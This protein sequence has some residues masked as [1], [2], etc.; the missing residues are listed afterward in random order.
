MGRREIARRPWRS[1]TGPGGRH[2]ARRAPRPRRRETPATSISPINTPIGPRSEPSSAPAKRQPQSPDGSV[3]FPLELEPVPLPPVSIEPPVPIDP[4]E[5]PM[6]PSGEAVHS[7]AWQVPFE[8]GSP[9][10][11]AGAEQAPVVLSHVPSTWHSSMAVQLLGLPP[12]QTPLMH[13]S[14]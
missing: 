10:L 13:V 9:S 6:P 7:P 12:T 2:A 5:P 3:G 11:F 1:T 14:V 4:P 8:H